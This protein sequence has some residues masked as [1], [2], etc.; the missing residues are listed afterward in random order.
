[1]L[2][3]GLSEDDI[4]ALV[5][6]DLVLPDGRKIGLRS[7]WG[8]NPIDIAGYQLQ[9]MANRKERAEAIRRQHE[10]NVQK[11]VDYLERE[12]S[13]E[14][15]IDWYGEEVASE[16]QDIYR[17]RLE[18]AAA[19]RERAETKRRDLGEQIET[20]LR[21]NEDMYS[22]TETAGIDDDTVPGEI[23]Q[24]LRYLRERLDDANSNLTRKHNRLLQGGEVALEADTAEATTL[25]TRV[26]VLMQRFRDWQQAEK[27]R[28]NRP[29]S[30]GDLAALMA[31]FNKH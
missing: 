15:V 28:E 12:Y 27:E 11:A 4:L 20:L 9:I 23:R 25:R 18:A 24:E 13:R 3:D 26:N 8:D 1:M 5:A 19:E 22:Y 21:D 6:D 16:A 30:G 10:R 14:Q 29:V 2:R 7:S 31:H 17:T